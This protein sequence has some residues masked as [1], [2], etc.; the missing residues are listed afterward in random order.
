MLPSFSAA[1][2][3]GR[4]ILLPRGDMDFTEGS[5]IQIEIPAQR[6]LFDILV[7]ETNIIHFDTNGAS[8]AEIIDATNPRNTA[9]KLLGKVA[10]AVVVRRCA[11]NNII[12]KKWLDKARRGN[13]RIDVANRFIAVGT[14][15]HST[16]RKYPHKY[17]PSDSQRDI[18]WMDE[19]GNIANVIGS[20]SVSGL[21]AGLQIKVSGN[22]VNYVQRA[23]VANRYEVPIVY[24][25][26]NNDFD[27]IVHNIN[28][29]VERGDISPVIVGEDLI[30]AID[31]DRAAYNSVREFYPILLDLFYGRI[32]ADDFVK[33]ATG[34]ASMQNA[35]LANALENRA[36]KILVFR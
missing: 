7:D 36:S 21:Q 23:V 12:N 4:A 26:L 16:K 35:I 27:R 34:I 8:L 3:D 5:T 17:N 6:R 28:R 22:G 30:N 20:N 32:S 10:E 11:D 14:G 33:E 18:I 25:P 15:L 9:I 29:K 24:F 2:D 19:N 13:S 1:L 31:I